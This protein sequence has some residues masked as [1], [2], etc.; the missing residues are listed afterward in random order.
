M[1][2]CEKNS[3]TQDLEAMIEELSTDLTEHQEITE[4]LAKVYVE[5]TSH[6][7]R[8]IKE[9]STLTMYIEDS[10]TNDETLALLMNKVKTLM[11]Q[12][13]FKYKTLH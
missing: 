12:P 9:F 4:R 8:V 7:E 5:L 1:D 2:G 6:H 3:N 11:I 10:V 13:N